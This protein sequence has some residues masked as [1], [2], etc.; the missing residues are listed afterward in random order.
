MRSKQSGRPLS[1]MK[2]SQWLQ[3]I[4]LVKTWRPSLT[5]CER[6]CSSFKTHST[7]AWR[8]IREKQYWQPIKVHSP[9]SKH[10]GMSSREPVTSLECLR[11]NPTNFATL[12]LIAKTASFPNSTQETFHC[13]TQ[14]ANYKISKRI[15]TQISLTSPR[16]RRRTTRLEFLLVRSAQDK[17]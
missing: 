4:Q 14:R 11:L 15:T 2:S 16:S 3:Y 8:Q 13:G 10:V 5:A 9:S 12:H 7:Y 17:G 1:L 6:K